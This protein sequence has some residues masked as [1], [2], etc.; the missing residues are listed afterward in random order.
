M[1][2][3]SQIVLRDFNISTITIHLI[4]ND[5]FVFEQLRDRGRYKYWKLSQSKIKFRNRNSR[6]PPH[7]DSPFFPSDDLYNYYD[8]SEALIYNKSALTDPT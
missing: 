8:H 1:R 4:L 6:D 2:M 5:P 7:E 3:V